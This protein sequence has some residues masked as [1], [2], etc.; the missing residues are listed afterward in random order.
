MRG[1]VLKASVIDNLDNTGTW[2]IAVQFDG[3]GTIQLDSFTSAGTTSCA[4]GFGRATPRLAG[5][6]P[7]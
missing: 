1:D 3:H 5:W 7:R 6:P 4:S 2:A